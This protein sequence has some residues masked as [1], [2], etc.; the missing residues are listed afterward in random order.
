M[1]T[2][3]IQT[4]DSAY[5]TPS[6]NANITY[7][8]SCQNYT[9]EKLSN[10]EQEARKS[11]L[12]SKTSQVRKCPNKGEVRW[13]VLIGIIKVLVIPARNN[14]NLFHNTKLFP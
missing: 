9:N 5:H 6:L 3:N 7:N 1:T 11:L 14:G 4:E 12:N 2:S 8:Q 10:E 13:R